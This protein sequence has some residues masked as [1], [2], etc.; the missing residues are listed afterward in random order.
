M[1]QN[2]ERWYSCLTFN[3]E[4]CPKLEITKRAYELKEK[5]PAENFD[6]DESSDMEEALSCCRDCEVYERYI[7]QQ[8]FF[9]WASCMVA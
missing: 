4:Q 1:E 5:K 3:Q 6:K 2:Q 7:P 9:P 8:K